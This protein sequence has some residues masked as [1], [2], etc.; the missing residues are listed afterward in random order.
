[1]LLYKP[2]TLH[3]T[4][5]A[6]QHAALTAEPLELAPVAL[7]PVAFWTGRRVTGAIIA[8]AGIAA[9][10]AGAVFGVLATNDKKKS[11]DACPT[12]AGE[13]RCQQGGVDAMNRANGEAWASD[14][15]F[16]LAVVGVGLGSVLFL[17]GGGH[18]APPAATASRPW[19][20]AVSG[21]PGSAMGV[22]T[23]R[24]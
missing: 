20:W 4:V 11:D 16:G 17:S 14:I 12:Y 8:V 13:I 6:K 5:A 19:S 24:F 10:G 1:A 7:P 3:V 22:V 2:K 18:E 21:G 23:G 9:A 15:A